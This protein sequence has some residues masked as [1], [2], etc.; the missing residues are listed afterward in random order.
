MVTFLYTYTISF[1]KILNVSYESLYLYSLLSNLNKKK[2]MIDSTI[3]YR[4]YLY[5][6]Q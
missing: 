4:I 1:N 2:I 5:I 6:K 3:I